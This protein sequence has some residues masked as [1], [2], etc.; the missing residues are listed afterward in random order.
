MAGDHAEDRGLDRQK[1]DDGGGKVSPAAE[2]QF[3]VLHLFNITRH[4]AFYICSRKSFRH[5]GGPSISQ[6][7]AFG[8]R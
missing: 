4:S 5:L 1:V 3:Y 7:Y 8:A 6:S 2:Q